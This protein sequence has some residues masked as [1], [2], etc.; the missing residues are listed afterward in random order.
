MICDFRRLEML[1]SLC[2]ICCFQE[3]AHIHDGGHALQPNTKTM[4]DCVRKT[5]Q[6]WLSGW[7][8]SL[9][10]LQSRILEL[11][12]CGPTMGYMGPI[13]TYLSSC[14][15]TWYLQFWSWSPCYSQEKMQW[16]K[17]DNLHERC[18][19][20]Q[21]LPQSASWLNDFAGMPRYKLVHVQPH[22]T[23]HY[24]AA[25]PVCPK[26]QVCFYT[27]APKIY[28][29]SLQ[30]DICSVTRPWFCCPA[31]RLSNSWKHHCPLSMTIQL[32]WQSLL[33]GYVYGRASTLPV[34]LHWSFT[35]LKL[36]VSGINPVKSCSAVLS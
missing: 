17:W 23:H 2:H 4:V 34:A 5:G 12:G 24:M 14:V 21:H 7:C 25:Y 11:Q 6:P 10:T 31:W 33:T 8:G 9:A 28:V 32:W 26:N 29:R 1:A 27:F 22:S 13:P 20:T 35:Q 30:K 36:Y 19:N 15:W 18:G 16:Q 3:F